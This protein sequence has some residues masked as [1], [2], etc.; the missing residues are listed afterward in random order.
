MQD[1][2]KYRNGWNSTGTLKTESARCH[3]WDAYGLSKLAMIHMACEI[4]RRFGGSYNLHAVAVHPG[5]VMTNLTLPYA[6]RGRIGKAVHRIS[7]ALTSLVLLSPY[8]GA[9]TTRDV[10]KHEVIAGR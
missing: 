2:N 8:A 7:S 1:S 9:Q 10:R 3:S 5:V 6:F 4:E